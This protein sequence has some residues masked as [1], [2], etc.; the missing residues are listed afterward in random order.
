MRHLVVVMRVAILKRIICPP[1]CFRSG[2]HA[3]SGQILQIVR[4]RGNDQIKR[5]GRHLAHDRQSVSARYGIKKS[6]Q[7]TTDIVKL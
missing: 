2:F 4:W 7:H 5:A 6:R 1:P 3:V